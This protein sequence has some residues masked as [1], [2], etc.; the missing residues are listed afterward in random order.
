MKDAELPSNSSGPP[1]KDVPDNANRST[2]VLLANEIGDEV[3]ESEPEGNGSFEK[4]DDEVIKKNIV[5][6]RIGREAMVGAVEGE[7]KELDGGVEGKRGAKLGDIERGVDQGDGVVG[8]N[9]LWFWYRCRK[10]EK[11]MVISF[12]FGAIAARR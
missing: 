8:G 4:A 6:L 11:D 12:G 5:V 9:F 1:K 2:N 3:L 10:E 7:L